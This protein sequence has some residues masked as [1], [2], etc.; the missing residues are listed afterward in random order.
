MANIHTDKIAVNTHKFIAGRSEEWEVV[1]KP[2]HLA[3]A[4]NHTVMLILVA[5]R[6]EFVSRITGR[7]LVEKHV[8]KVLPREFVD[9][10]E[11]NVCNATAYGEAFNGADRVRK[12]T[13]SKISNLFNKPASNV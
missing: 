7:L 3:D 2:P 6:H 5:F 12:Y 4:S 8:N 9:R 10:F 11:F 13:R 1:S